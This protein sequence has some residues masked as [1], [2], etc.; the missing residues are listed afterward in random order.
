MA[1]ANLSSGVTINPMPPRNG[2]PVAVTYKGKLAQNSSDLTL[3]VSYGEPGKFF[4]MQEVAMQK[5]GNEYCAKFTVQASDRINMYF[6]DDHGTKD[7]NQGN[8][9]QALVDSDNLSYS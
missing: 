5:D 1:T 6:V 2:D 3:N 7:D 8:Y 9:Y 4:G